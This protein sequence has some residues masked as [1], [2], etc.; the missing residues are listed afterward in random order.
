M[1]RL[2]QV[3]VAVVGTSVLLGLCRPPL[4]TAGAPLACTSDFEGGSGTV[5]AIDQQ[6]RIVRITPTVY[7]DRGWVC[8]WYVKVTGI[9]PGETITL[10]VRSR[11]GNWAKPA[12]AAYSTDNRTWLHTATA[13]REKDR[14]EYRQK[15]D[16]PAAWFAW[17][18]PFVPSDVEKL[19]AE[20]AKRCPYAEK[21][22][23]CRTREGRPVPALRI[24]QPGA[25]DAA[26][27]GVWIN[28]RQHAWESG[29]SWVSRGLI[30]WL[31]SDDP[32]AAA[33]R[34]ESLIVIVPI[35]DVDNAFR[36]AGG[37]QQKPHDHNRDWSDKPHWHSV[38]AAIE[39]IRELDK[40]GRFDL[41]VDLHNPAAGD[42][43]PFFFTSPKDVLGEPGR[44]NQERFLEAARAEITGPLKL[45]S[46]RTE[47][48]P[49]YDPM[50][51]QISNTW[52]A[53]HTRP[54][55]V[56][57]C[58]ETSWDTPHSTTEGY[59]AVGRQLGLAIERYFRRNPRLGTKPSLED[60]PPPSR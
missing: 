55:V 28:A 9:R 18:P 8:W 33:L 17:G 27:Y 35:M 32:R 48:G 46:K 16:A 50:W 14:I 37:K 43:Q 38:A 19:L 49:R 5:Q 47:S 60:N 44:R 26:R 7:K 25:A 34:K 6:A 20:V 13:K 39:R 4:A 57:L 51:Q 15:V 59:L 2:H 56:A 3:I 21:F 24:C 52:V 40:Q 30:E 58:L 10:D 53:A 41:Y 54:H 42:R 29:G 12:Q 23:L 31:V 45:G 36:G 22:E 1:K 11:F